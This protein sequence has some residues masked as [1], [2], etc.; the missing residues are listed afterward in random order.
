MQVTNLEDGWGRLVLDN[1]SGTG[2]LAETIAINAD[3]IN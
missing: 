3:Y 1:S 2:T